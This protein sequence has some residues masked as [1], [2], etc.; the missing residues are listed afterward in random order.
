MERA[1]QPAYQS[2]RSATVDQWLA[3]L[4]THDTLERYPAVAVI[5]AMFHAANGRP[6]ESER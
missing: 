3:W 1:I 6:T 2:G 5:G 4:Q